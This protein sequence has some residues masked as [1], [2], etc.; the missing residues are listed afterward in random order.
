VLVLRAVHFFT[1]PRLLCINATL[2]LCIHGTVVISYLALFSSEKI[3]D[4]GTVA[5][6][7]VCDKYYLI[8]DKLGSKDSSRDF[9]LNCVISF[10]FHLYLM[11]N[12]CA[13]RF[14]VT[15]NLENFLLLV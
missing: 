14:D 13:A 3:S 15:E 8:M 6:L 11:F 4:F 1:N 10:C 12:A 9:Q 7:F 5:L 2:L